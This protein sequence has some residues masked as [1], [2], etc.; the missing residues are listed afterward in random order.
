MTQSHQGLTPILIIEELKI[1]VTEAINQYNLK[2][3][4]EK[5]QCY[6]GVQGRI[7]MKYA[8]EE[9]YELRFE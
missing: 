7:Q 3:T 1:T 5:G 8:W 6:P 2:L 9:E 4:E